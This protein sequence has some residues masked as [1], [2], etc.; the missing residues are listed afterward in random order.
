M[1]QIFDTDLT[2]AEL[3]PFIRTANVMVTQ[4]LSALPAPILHEI[5]LYLSAHYAT[6]I[7]PRAKQEKIGNEYAVTYQGETGMGFQATH[8]GQ[9]ALSLDTSNIL[10]TLGQ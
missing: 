7:D 6:V 5:E 4:H 10:A 9:I 3:L 8:Y 2:A 1:K